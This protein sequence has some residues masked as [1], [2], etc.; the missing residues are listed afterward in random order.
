MGAQA[1][2]RPH[3]ATVRNLRHQP[4]EGGT[5]NSHS[6]PGQSLSLVQTRLKT[7][8]LILGVPCKTMR[9]LKRQI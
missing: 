6:A 9:L 3:S 2:L 8:C 5:V 7:Y 1:L 4:G